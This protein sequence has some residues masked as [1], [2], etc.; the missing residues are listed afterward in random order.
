[1]SEPTPIY[2]QLLWE[3]TWPYVTAASTT[4]AQFATQMKAMGEAFG[5]VGATL[6]RF[7]LEADDTPIERHIMLTESDDPAVERFRR[8]LRSIRRDPTPG[9]GPDAPKEGS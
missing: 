1:M 8:K 2:D 9:W 6:A 4:T 5:R 3:R 7:R